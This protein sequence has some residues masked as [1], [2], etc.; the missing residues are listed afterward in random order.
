MSKKDDALAYHRRGRKGKLEVVPTKPLVS[1]IDLSLAY[2][3]GVA[4]PCLEIAEGVDKSWEDTARRNLVAVI[5]NG[6]GV[7][8]LGN[9]G[10]AAG[11]PVME[12]KACLFKKF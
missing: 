3:P 8:G 11:K 6:P 12:G 1:Q 5:S 7:L 2:T 9:I 4:E 10:P